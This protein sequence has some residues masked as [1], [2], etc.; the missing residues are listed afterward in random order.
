[1]AHGVDKWQQENQKL[2]LRKLQSKKKGPSNDIGGPRWLGSILW[3][4]SMT[5]FLAL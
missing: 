1:M 4:V 2:R 5:F 3:C